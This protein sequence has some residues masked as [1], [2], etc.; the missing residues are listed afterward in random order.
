[1]IITGLDGIAKAAGLSSGAKAVMERLLEVFSKN[2]QRNTLRRLYFEG[3]ARPRTLGIS[4][5]DDVRLD[6]SCSWPEKAVM[7]L[8]NRSNFDGFV[9]AD[10]DGAAEATRRTCM[11]AKYARALPS[12]LVH[13]CTFATLTSRDGKAQVN[14]HSAETAAGL[15]D[16]DADRISAGF[17]I[18]DGERDGLG[19]Y[20]PTVVNLYMDD[21]TWVMRRN[22]G[23]W[24]AEPHPHSMG[25]P[26]MEPLIYRGDT[27]KPFGHSRITRPVM[28]IADSYMREMERIE[29]SAEFYTNPQR[30]AAGL[31]DDQLEAL[32]KDKWKYVTGSIM[33]FTENPNTGDPP[34]VGQFSQ[35]SMGPHI[36]YINSLANQFSGVTSIPVSDLGV[37]QSTYVSA[38]AVQTAAA[39]LCIEA[40][41]LNMDNQAHL[42]V[43]MA[44]ALAIDG[45]MAFGEAS[46]LDFT[47]HFKDPRKPSLVAQADAV[48]KAIQAVPKLA[49]SDYSLEQLG[50]SQ[51]DIVRINSDAERA[52]G[53][54]D[55][56]E[57][58]A[59]YGDAEA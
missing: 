19:S 58:E 56:T 24:S 5:P 50:I 20:K 32:V 59:E 12:E 16:E 29:V 7:A 10:S 37:V 51:A 41:K 8:A 42:D 45:D 52:A 13:G 44:M 14:F 9:G 23:K 38:E 57:Y 49:Q 6:V 39:N 22:G 17:A 25:R 15:Y 46:Q 40:E 26:M 53:L 1:M 18:I 2:L 28:M 43:I 11:V 47:A 30:W 4:I 54:A 55:L 3:K 35:M 48:L 36:D 31:S 33:G 27:L 34:T 21:A